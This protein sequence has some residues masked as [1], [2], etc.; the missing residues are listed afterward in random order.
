[1]NRAL[2][3]LRITIQPCLEQEL[4][5]SLCCLQ[6]ANHKKSCEPITDEEGLLSF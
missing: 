5:H 1:M 4:T 3:A 6:L 2:P